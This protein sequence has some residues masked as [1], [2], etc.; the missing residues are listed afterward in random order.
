MGQNVGQGPQGAV[1]SGR[2]KQEQGRLVR[3]ES[4]KGLEG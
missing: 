1:R 2:E 4:T 3:G